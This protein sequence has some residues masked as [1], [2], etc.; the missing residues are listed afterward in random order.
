MSFARDSTTDRYAPW[1]GL[2]SMTKGLK[3]HAIT[4]QVVVSSFS[5]E[6]LLTMAWMGV[7]WVL[8][9]KGISTV[10]APM[11]ESKRSDR[12][13]LEQTF[14]SPASSSMPSRKSPGTSLC[15]SFS[16]GRVAEICFSAPL[17]S[18]KSREMLTMV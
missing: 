3:P 5:T 8:P 18:R 11:V 12:P 6:T 9:P 4:E 17:V 16:S 14:R 15:H 13:L 10:P 7:V 1:N 2:F